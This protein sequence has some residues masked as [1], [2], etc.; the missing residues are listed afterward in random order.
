[1]LIIL[2]IFGYEA[3]V[4]EYKRLRIVRRGSNAGM[5]MCMYFQLEVVIRATNAKLCYLYLG[6]I[7][8]LTDEE[9]T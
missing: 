6:V 8:S 2:N 7:A 3:S 5:S 9:D 4:K 1:M